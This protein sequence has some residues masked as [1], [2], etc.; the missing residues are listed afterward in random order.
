MGNFTFAELRCL[1]QAAYDTVIEN[2]SKDCAHGVGGI[3]YPTVL[4]NDKRRLGGLIALSIKSLDDHFKNR[5]LFGGPALAADTRRLL[6]ADVVASAHLQAR[7]LGWLDKIIKAWYP[8]GAAPASPAPEPTRKKS[9]YLGSAFDAPAPPKPP[10]APAMFSLEKAL[11]VPVGDKIRNTYANLYAVIHGTICLNEM[12][13]GMDDVPGGVDA[14]QQS[15]YAF[16]KVMD[17]IFKGEVAMKGE[18]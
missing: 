6:V 7:D 2:P 3:F 1:A 5:E 9:V 8:D 13:N 11:G 17:P 15:L 18:G 4:D 14:L 12:A 10:A 16:A